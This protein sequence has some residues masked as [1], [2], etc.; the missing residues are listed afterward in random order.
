MCG[1]QADGDGLVARISAS[2]ASKAQTSGENSQTL[3]RTAS[4]EP[5]CCKQQNLLTSTDEYH[6]I[7]SQNIHVVRIHEVVRQRT[8]TC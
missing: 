7:L 3:Y 1:V 2:A 4:S 8:R 5:T 6:I